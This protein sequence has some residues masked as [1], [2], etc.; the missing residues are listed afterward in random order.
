MR[1]YN[2]YTVTVTVT[3]TVRTHDNVIVPALQGESLQ[4]LAFRHDIVTCRLSAPENADFKR[5][6]HSGQQR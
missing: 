1:C 5:D 2:K 3:V 4:L 6:F